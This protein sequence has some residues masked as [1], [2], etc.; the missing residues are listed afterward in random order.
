MTDPSTVPRRTLATVRSWVAEL[1]LLVYN[2]L[3]V[4]VPAHALRNAF[5]TRVMGVSLGDGAAVLMGVRLYSTRNLTIG[6]HAVVDRDC[7]LDNRG[8]IQIGENVN[9]APEVMILTA[10]HDPDD[11]Q[12]FSAYLR[13]VVV[14]DYAWLATR[15]LILP[16]V[17]IG[18]G[19]VVAAGAVVTKDVAPATI[20]A[21]NPAR[22]VGE[23]QGVQAY[24][25]D[26]RRRFH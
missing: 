15:A 4:H 24:Q 11:G 9:L 16:G 19:A 12:A 7:V 10:S 3:V 8:G 6:P 20:V 1:R 26:Y 17:R 2:H 18:R 21:G 22:P 14:E 13:P 5:L 25:L 23:R